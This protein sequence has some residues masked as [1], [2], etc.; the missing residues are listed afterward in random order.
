MKHR[1]QFHPTRLVAVAMLV[2]PLLFAPAAV[3]A[4]RSGEN[5]AAIDVVAGSIRFVPQV[6]YGSVRVSVTGPGGFEV[7][8]SFGTDESLAVELPGTDGLYKYELRF[9]PRLDRQDLERLAE[10]RRSGQE[11]AVSDLALSDR[12]SV[13][14]GWFRL[15]D[16][17]LLPDDLVEEAAASSLADEGSSSA[18]APG[19]N[20]NLVLT[21][22]DGVIR[23]SLCVGFDCPNSPT[24]S[25]STILLME[26]NT[27]IKFGDTSSAAGFPNN[28]WEIQANSN[29]NG[30]GN[31]LG[32][33]DCGVN[34]ND[35]GCGNDLVFAVEA[36]APTSALYVESDGDVGFGISN[37]VVD[38]HVIDG[39]TPTLRL[40]QDGSG[41]FQPQ[42][43]DVAG[44]ETN[45]FI[46]DVTNGS[47]LPLRIRP[48]SPSNSIFIDGSSGGDVGFGTSAPEGPIHVRRTDANAVNILV[49][50]T[51]N[52]NAQLR[53][54]NGTGNTWDLRNRT[55]GEFA[56]TL[57]GSG[58]TELNL[59]TAG[60]MEIFGELTTGGATCGGG[61]CDQVFSPGYEID[62][63]EEHAAQMWAQ[64]HLP[65][66]GPTPENQPFNLSQKTGGLIHEVE[67]AHIYIE[68]LHGEL[69]RLRQRLAQVEASLAAGESADIVD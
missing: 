29:S 32:I 56:I 42:T 25:D 8:R 24:F 26:N 34:D 37:P 19:P 48:G 12:Q 2:S 9:A 59:D 35:G 61:G 43:W 46:R 27:R 65:A 40:E 3:A 10:A 28:D 31:Y 50:S 58:N 18:N 66:I 57:A 62:S 33:N 20:T 63:I 30:G 36:G 38:L 14:R 45:F 17:G 4:D 49:D 47:A 39:N 16:G 51:Q 5:L 21:T 54:R 23:N 41:G 13:Q 15:L 44:N 11:D 67:K 60:N 64:R 52:Q 1:R 68:Q 22:S 55:N 69:A 7:V 6:P 53:L